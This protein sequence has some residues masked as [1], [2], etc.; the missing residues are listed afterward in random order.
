MMQAQKVYGPIY[1]D[2]LVAVNFYSL[3]TNEKSNKNKVGRRGN[4]GT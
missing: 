3:D 4:H 2:G 1:D